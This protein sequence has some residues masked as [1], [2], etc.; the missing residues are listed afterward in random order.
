MKTQN[1]QQQQSPP[2]RPQNNSGGGGE[3]RSVDEGGED[4]KSSTGS[5]E[6]KGESNVGGG[7][8]DKS[9]RIEND[10]SCSELERVWVR[11]WFPVLFE[12]SCIINSGKLDIRTRSLT[13]LF[14][15]V[16]NYGELFEVITIYC[17]R[18]NQHIIIPQIGYSRF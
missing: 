3:N 12:L 1:Q 8:N 15:I 16:K 4:N 13:V 11:G 9:K 10:P 5:D 14:D 18:I 6:D 17:F 7:E 2:S